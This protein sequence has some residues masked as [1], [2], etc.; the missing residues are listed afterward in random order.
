[1][2]T[3][4]VSA[5]GTTINGSAFGFLKGTVFFG[6]S[7][8]VVGGAAPDEAAMQSEATTVLAELP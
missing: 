4:S 6:F 8:L 7:D 3:L 2:A 5:E 1:M